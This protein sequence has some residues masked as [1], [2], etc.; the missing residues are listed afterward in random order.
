MFCRGTGAGRA[1]AGRMARLCL[2][3]P[4]LLAWSGSALFGMV[5]PEYM[6]AAR[7][8]AAMHLQVEVEEV[9]V[10]AEMPGSCLL[11]AKIRRIFDDRLGLLEMGQT[12]HLQVSCARSGDRLPISGTLWTRVED[13]KAAKFLE[14]YLDLNADSHF[15]RIPTLNYA[16]SRTPIDEPTL[17]PEFRETHFVV[18]IDDATHQ[19]GS[20]EATIR[21][22]VYKVFRDESKLLAP[23]RTIRFALDC[24]TADPRG[25]ST[26]TCSRF[27]KTAEKYAE[28]VFYLNSPFDQVGIIAKLT[29]EPTCPPEAKGYWCA[30]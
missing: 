27:V 28:V 13:L 29:S 15:P 26:P 20:Q 3:M 5:P 8:N 14:A 23:G 16:L 9:T 7:R 30:R 17:N 12:L 11:R 24:G 2:S 10:P 6:E 4:A 19:P 18:A 21:G 25:G 1:Q 22:K